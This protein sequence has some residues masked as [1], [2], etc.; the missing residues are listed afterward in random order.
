M[1]QE[2]REIKSW[3]V[4]AKEAVNKKTPFTSKMDLNLKTN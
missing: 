2:E 4:M 3:T 1:M